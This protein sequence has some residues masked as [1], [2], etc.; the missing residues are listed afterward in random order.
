[1]DRPPWCRIVVALLV[2]TPPLCIT[3]SQYTQ[4]IEEAVLSLVPYHTQAQGQTHTTHTAI[5]NSDKKIDICTKSTSCL[6]GVALLGVVGMVQVLREPENTINTSH[7]RRELAS[8]ANV[9]RIALLGE[10]RVGAYQSVHVHILLIEFHS[11]L[12][13]LVYLGVVCLYSA[14][15]WYVRSWHL[16]CCER[17]PFSSSIYHM[18]LLTLYLYMHHYLIFMYCIT[19]STQVQI[20]LLII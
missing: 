10:V 19:H 11:T 8:A 12:T 4:L 2:N 3:T 18:P 13:H 16:L 6:I 15:L 17:D 5:M 9:K 20:G 7:T 1:M 14:P